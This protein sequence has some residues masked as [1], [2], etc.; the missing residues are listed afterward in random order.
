VSGNKSLSRSIERA[1]TAVE[2][3][4]DRTRSINETRRSHQRQRIRTHVSVYPEGLHEGEIHHGW[5]YDISRGGIGFVSEST[6]EVSDSEVVI[7]IDPEGDNPLWMRARIRSCREVIDGVNACG[8]Q[9]VGKVPKL[10]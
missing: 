7:C 2:A 1:L 9:F 5:A 6:L 8:A 10:D 4:L 3:Y